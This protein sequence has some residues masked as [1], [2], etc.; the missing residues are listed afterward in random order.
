MVRGGPSRRIWPFPIDDTGV[1]LGSYFK[2]SSLDSLGYKADINKAAVCADASEALST[3]ETAKLVNA[4]LL[5]SEILGCKLK[6]NEK[7]VYIQVF[8]A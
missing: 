3:P 2:M 8:Q 5:S 4:A 7:L 6:E 1:S